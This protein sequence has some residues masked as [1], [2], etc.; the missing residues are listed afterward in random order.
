[1]TRRR[2]SLAQPLLL[3]G[4][5]SCWLCLAVAGY[6]WLSYAGRQAQQQQLE[7]LADSQVQHLR[8]QLDRLQQDA[9]LLQQ[10]LQ[11]LPDSSHG[12]VAPYLQ[13]FRR[14]HGFLSQLA[15]LDAKRAPG[16]PLYVA[17]VLPLRARGGLQ[18][19]DDLARQPQLAAALPALMRGQAQSMLWQRRAP[20]QVLLV[21][22]ARD[23]RLL[24]MWFVPQQLLRDDGEA[25]DRTWLSASPVAPQAAMAADTLLSQRALPHPLLTLNLTLWQP[26]QALGQLSWRLLALLGCLL[27][28]WLLGWHGWQQYRSLG[29]D[30]QHARRMQAQWLQQAAALAPVSAQRALATLERHLLQLPPGQQLLVWWVHGKGVRRRGLHIGHALFRVENQLAQL[31]LPQVQLMRLHHG[32]MLIVLAQPPEQLATLTPGLERWLTRTL[33]GK[34]EEAALLWRRFDISQGVTELEAGLT[35]PDLL[36]FYHAA[37]RLAGGR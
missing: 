29:L 25:H 30:I 4:L 24:A 3:M 32:G 35:D 23:G 34:P 17:S 26:W 22:P 37:N 33:G 18:I 9:S 6:A 21:L 15:L 8:G 19:G 28:L 12:R 10:Q 11:H 7:V 13:Q 16:H 20:E 1:M 36:P 5:F 31:H 14:E 2:A 27:L